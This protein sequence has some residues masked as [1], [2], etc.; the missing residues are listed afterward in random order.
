MNTTIFKKI[1]ATIKMNA[2]PHSML[3]GIGIC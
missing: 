2:V 3:V 1:G